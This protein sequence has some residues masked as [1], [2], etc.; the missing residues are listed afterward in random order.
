[1]NIEDLDGYLDQ[2]LSASRTIK[3]R[4]LRHVQAIAQT[5][6]ELSADPRWELYDRQIQVLIEQRRVALTALEKKLN[7]GETLEF[8][9]YANLKQQIAFSRG[10]IEALKASIEVVKIWIERGEKAGEE[11]ASS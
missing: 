2:K 7:E 6:S 5:M 1:M 10:W 4:Q 11:I 3:I 8:K 9:D